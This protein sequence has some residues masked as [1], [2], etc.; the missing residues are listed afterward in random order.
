MP[1]ASNR[2]GIHMK[3]IL[4]LSTVALAALLFVA[5]APSGAETGTAAEAP[6]PAVET[7]SLEVVTEVAATELEF[8]SEDPELCAGID[9]TED[10]QQSAAA[11]GGCSI[12][13]GCNQFDSPY[14]DYSCSRNHDY[15]CEA[16]ILI[17]GSYCPYICA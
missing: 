16:K 14:C 13:G 12:F 4:A 8:A 10:W 17:P 3:K 6:T 1:P 11:P 9:A 7:P 5:I 15:C 2:E